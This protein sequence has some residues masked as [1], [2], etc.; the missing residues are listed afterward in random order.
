[1]MQQQF[2]LPYPLALEL[3][4]LT[5][6]TGGQRANVEQA[7]ANAHHARESTRVATT[8]PRT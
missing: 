8:P 6:A 2:L 7:P 3:L 1:V 5:H 4:A